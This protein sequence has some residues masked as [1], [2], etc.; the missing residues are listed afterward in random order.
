M[1]TPAQLIVS[2]CTECHG[3]FLPRPGPCPRCGSNSIR[4]EPVPDVGEVLAATELMVPPAG[5]PSPHRLALVELM[6]GVRL[7]GLV[8]GTLP[9]LGDHVK[10]T[11]DADRYTCRAVP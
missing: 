5:W 6:H 4:P 3:R 7:L 8:E 2:L 1:S 9:E 11:R 10:V